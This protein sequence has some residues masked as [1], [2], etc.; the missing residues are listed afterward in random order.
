MFKENNIE[1]KGSF[2][3]TVQSLG[4]TINLR[5]DNQLLS[6][7]PLIIKKDVFVTFDEIKNSTYGDNVTISGK[8][9]EVNGRT[10]SNSNVKIIVNGKKFYAKTDNKGF[11]SLITRVTAV[12][13]NN[14][15]IGYSGNDKYNSYEVNTTFNADK[16]D[17]VVT[18]TVI[19]I[20][21]VGE[22]VTITG[23]FTDKNGKAIVNSN[24]KILIN[25]KKYLSGNPRFLSEENIEIASIEKTID[26]LSK[27]GKTPLIF[28]EGKKII[29]IIAVS[30]TIRNDSIEAIK[31]FK[32]LGKA[33]LH[34]ED[35]NSIVG[36]RLAESRAKEK[37]FKQCRN[38]A[39]YL[40]FNKLPSKKEFEMLK[41]VVTNSI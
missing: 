41:C 26:E 6:L 32:A 30:D 34:E 20:P 13:I 38:L 7:Q 29:G 21:K 11:Y 22:N 31:A 3:T 5:V 23:T 28:A 33:R 8:F 12:G 35:T 1:F 36:R 10:I 24:V 17:V 39:K 37:I 27:Q 4:D 2:N 25:G 14:V 19:N 18:G 15:S 9:S 16:Q 40:A